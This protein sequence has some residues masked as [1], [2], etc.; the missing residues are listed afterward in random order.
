MGIFLRMCAIF[1]GI[2]AVFQFIPTYEKINPEID[3]FL[4]IKAP[5]N[6]M[7]IFKRS[8]YDCHSNETR[9]PWYSD[10]A[11]MSWIVRRDVVNGR[12]ALNFSEWE[13]YDEEKKKELKKQIY[14]SVA[15]AMPI[16]QYLWT[17]PEAKLSDDDK[18][19]IR[20]WASGGSGYMH[21]EVR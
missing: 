1:L 9:W 8:C 15:F 18:L 19:I 2:F 17:H 13:N 21:Y 12:R 3:S 5:K 20:K 11:P 14:R 16:P 4:E 6:V 7:Q 10:V